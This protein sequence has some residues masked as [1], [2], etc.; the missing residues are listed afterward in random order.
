MVSCALGFVGTL[1]LIQIV[2][3]QK[4]KGYNKSIK[5]IGYVASLLTDM[6]LYEHHGVAPRLKSI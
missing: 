3:S 5:F 2:E 1:K 4:L 6:T